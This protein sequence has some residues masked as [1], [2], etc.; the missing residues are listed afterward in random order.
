MKCRNCKHKRI[1]GIVHTPIIGTN[2][3]RH[4]SYCARIFNI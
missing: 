2:M 4:C 1:G 3:C